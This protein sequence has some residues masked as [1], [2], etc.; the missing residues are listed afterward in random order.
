LLVR[1]F[2]I[3]LAP[4]QLQRGLC[5]RARRS[6]AMGR[7]WYHGLWSGRMNVK[8]IDRSDRELSGAAKMHQRHRDGHRCRE[9]RTNHDDVVDYSSFRPSDETN[10]RTEVIVKI[11]WREPVEDGLS[12]SPS[13]QLC[14]FWYAGSCLV[15]QMVLRAECVTCAGNLYSRHRRCIILDLVY[16]NPGFWTKN[17]TE[18]LEWQ[19]CE[20]RIAGPSMDMFIEK[21]LCAELRLCCLG[22]SHI[23]H[24]YDVPELRCW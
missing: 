19:I 14:R 4:A 8:I 21:I 12:G 16:H 5:G 11:S 2:Q 7:M 20:L 13:F 6:M 3:S 23:V 17:R 24:A 18:A 22:R 9:I 1:G 10:A 15:V